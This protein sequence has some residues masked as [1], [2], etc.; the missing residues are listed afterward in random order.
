[1]RYYIKLTT[2]NEVNTLGFTLAAD[3][4]N[5]QGGLSTVV[6]YFCLPP[7]HIASSIGYR[8][9][10]QSH[11]IKFVTASAIFHKIRRLRLQGDF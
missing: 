9:I 6:M 4:T 3:L 7:V 8:L 11:T 2:R 5:Q 10:E 1:M